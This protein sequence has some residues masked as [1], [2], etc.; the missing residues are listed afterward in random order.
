MRTGPCADERSC[1]A[2][3]RRDALVHRDRLA[4]GSVPVDHRVCVALAEAGLGPSGAA[5]YG[6]FACDNDCLGLRVGRQQV[7]GDVAAT[8]VFGQ[9][10]TH[11][12]EHERR[13]GR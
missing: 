7:G 12:R 5:Q 11:V 10:A 9:R 1:I 13:T 8:E 3:E 4:V 2:D 6:V